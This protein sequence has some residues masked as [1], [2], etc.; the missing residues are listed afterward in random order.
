MLGFF[1]FWLAGLQDLG[2]NVNKNVKL[3]SA[4]AHAGITGR[5]LARR[6]GIHHITVSRL[7][8]QRGR[9]R[10]QTAT[11]IAQALNATP[12]ELGL[13]VWA[14]GPIDES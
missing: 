13:D 11:A 7:L 3:L 2:A 8:N 4:I 14:G 6:A 12:V 9:C 5:T 1:M 10:P